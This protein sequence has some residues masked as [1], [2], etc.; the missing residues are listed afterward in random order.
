MGEPKKG[1][2]NKDP[3]H[4]PVDVSKRKKAPG[5]GVSGHPQSE[6]GSRQGNIGH[7][8]SA[9]SGRGDLQD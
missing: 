3:N 5:Q 1:T 7:E 4:D 8:Y 2:G 6:G 9:A